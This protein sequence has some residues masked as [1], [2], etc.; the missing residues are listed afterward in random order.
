M[1]Q[2][3]LTPAQR[4]DKRADA[5][6][7]D[8]VVM[9]GADGLTAAVIKETDAALKAHGLIKVRV[10]GD[11]RAAREAMLNT[12]CDQLDAAPIQ[13]IGK[14]LVIW[15]PIPEKVKSEREDAQPGPRVV[16][17]VKFSK[18]GNHR[19]QVSKVKVMGNERVTQ[20]GEIKRA[21]RRQTSVKKSTAD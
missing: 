5:H 16:K 9:I 19:P 17:I 11:D 18:S 15:R 2:I 6:H 3:N 4:K 21:K 20:G 13:H 12:L 14:L 10:F 7:L 1:P 8:P